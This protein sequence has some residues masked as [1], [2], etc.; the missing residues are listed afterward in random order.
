MIMEMP[1]LRVPMPKPVLYKTWVRMRSFLYIAAPLLIVGSLIIGALQVSGALHKIVEPLSPI[2]TGL[3]GLPAVAII[4]LIYGFI[5]KEG[6]IV[7]LT[8]VAGTSNLATFMSPL[9]LFVFA[10]VVAIY[11]PCIATIAVLGREVGWK[12][13]VLITVSTFLLALIVG[14]LVYHLNPLGLAV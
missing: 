2:T 12:W 1:P 13:A 4:P 14:G 6:A 9:Q 5:R 11:I 10:L 3:L 7:L 8:V